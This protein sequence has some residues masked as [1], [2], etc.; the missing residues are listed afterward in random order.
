M[1]LDH[2]GAFHKGYLQHTPDAGF[3]FV[4][5]R[6]PRSLRVDWSVPLPD[7][8]QRWTTLVG[9]NVLVPG[10]TMVSSFL[11]PSSSR[12][13]HSANFVSAKNLLSPCP[14]SLIKALDPSN[15]DRDTWLRSYNEETDGLVANDMY[16]RISEKRY[17]ALRRANVIPKAIPSMC[18][19]VVKPDKDG[20]PSRAKSRIAVLGNYEEAC[21]TKSQRYAPVLKQTSLR[22]LVSEAVRHKRV[23]QQGDCKNTF[24]QAVLPDDERIAVRPPVGDPAR[25]ADEL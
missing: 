10:H 13:A 24:C 11:R 1:T 15:P 8:K 14:P 25:D 19:L 4:V 5:R 7:F 6:N 16:E 21:Y 12:T 3:A 23:L 18:V 9:E 22:L 17:L 2:N 20:N